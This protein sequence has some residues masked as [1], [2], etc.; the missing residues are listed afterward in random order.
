MNAVGRLSSLNL[1]MTKGAP[2]GANGRMDGF[3]LEGSGNGNPEFDLELWAIDFSAGLLLSTVSSP[4]CDETAVPES[5]DLDISLLDTSRT[6]STLS[7][8]DG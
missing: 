3:K 7:C 4:C 2:N 8:L 1:F 6:V 5:L